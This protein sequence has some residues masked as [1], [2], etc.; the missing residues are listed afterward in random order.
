MATESSFVYILQH[1]E[2]P[3][4]QDFTWADPNFQ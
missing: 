2:E 3:Q 4:T 1:M